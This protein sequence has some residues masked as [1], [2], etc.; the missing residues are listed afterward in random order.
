VD[1]ALV[2]RHRR[3]VVEERAMRVVDAP[4]GLVSEQ[5][6]SRLF[7][8]PH[9]LHAG[10]GGSVSELAG[11]TA[12][13]VR[14]FV[15]RHLVPANGV[16]VLVG[17]FDPDQAR[18]L[19]EDGLGRLPPGQRV[20]VPA[21]PP[22]SDGLVDQRA[23]PL[24]REPRVSLAWRLPGLARDSA[25]AL[26]LG[27]ELLTYMTDGAWGMR[28]AA[29][30]LPYR[31]EAIFRLDVTAP[32][33]ESPRAMEDDAESFLRF[34]T[35]REMPVELLSAAH[36]ALDRQ[37]LFELDSVPGRAR[38]L[39]ALEHL[40]PPR[41]SPGDHFG[42]HWRLDRGA[43]RDTARSYLRPPVVVMHARPTRPRAAKLE[44]E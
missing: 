26:E 21:L 42:W 13:D 34:L 9:P 22:P 14:A 28:V 38:V 36:L 43:L 35:H 37:A 31:A 27:A 39:T 4:Y 44:R 15:A 12:E 17:R 11:V 41:L 33:A 32:Y 29:G 19:V 25:L 23:E 6:S 2:E 24:G 1:G 18:R 16:L 10:V 40:P 8:A 7:A 3:V 5:L 20:P 30:L